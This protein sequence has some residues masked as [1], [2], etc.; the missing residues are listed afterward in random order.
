MKCLDLVRRFAEVSFND[1]PI[2]E[3]AVL[4]LGESDWSTARR[5]VDFATVLF[6]AETVGAL[7]RVFD[8]T[9]DYSFD[10]YTF[11]RPIASYQ[12]LK[13]RF[14]EVR[15]WLEACNATVSSAVRG[16]G[17]GDDDA[18]ELV[19]VAKSYV[20]DHAVAMVQEC[21]QMH[22]GVGVTWDHD[23]HLYLRRVTTNR[24]IFGSPS[25]HRARLASLL[26]MPAEEVM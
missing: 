14:A 11:G 2:S 16:V 20:G 12:A 1:V 3:N 17:S 22:G 8:F 7:N 13:H 25:Q 24:A 19:S 21:V 10:R 15:L 4:N 6:L 18:S 5:Q 26:G 23:L 9:L